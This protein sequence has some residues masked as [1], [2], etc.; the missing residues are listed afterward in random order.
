VRKIRLGLDID[1]VIYKW[2]ETARYLLLTHWGLENV[3]FEGRIENHIPAEINA[4]LWSEGV[5]D[6]GL[7]RYGSI[8]KGSREFL[9][10][11]EPFCDN[12]IIT[13]RPFNAIPDTLDWLAYQK[14]PTAEIHIVGPNK[15]KSEVTPHC[16]VY[17][18]D[19]IGNVNDFLENT[20]ARVIMPDRPWNQDLPDKI[21]GWHRCYSWTQI[22]MDLLEIHKE[23]NA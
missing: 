22:E 19:E 1:G 6:H 18:D 14:L 5:K 3:S 7:F 15:S 10:K 13:R 12:V 21:M 11:I 20:K 4:W 17:L 2:P 23:I 9:A 8:Y 16:D